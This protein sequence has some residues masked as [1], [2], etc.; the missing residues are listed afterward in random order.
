[1][2]ASI[3]I[4]TVS[5]T[6]KQIQM[7]HRTNSFLDKMNDK[8][9]RPRGLFCL[10]MTYKPFSSSKRVSVDT[11][12]TIAKTLTPADSEFKEKLKGIRTSSG[13][14]VGEIEL[15]ESAPLIFPAIDEAAVKEANKNVLV[16]GSSFLT[17]YLDRR[18]QA[19]YVRLFLLHPIIIIIITLSCLF[20]VLKP[21]P[22]PSF[23]N[24]PTKTPPPNSASIPQN[25]NTNLPPATPTPTT[26]P[27]TAPS[28]PCSPAEK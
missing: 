20:S 14:T 1:M 4:Q 16:R 10:M 23:V 17:E 25:H 3:L 13:V 15:P 5:E 21:Y 22:N 18:A 19:A 27:Q 9:F 2:V 6:S 26:P 12:T 24:R 7:R 11:S 28:S 8:F